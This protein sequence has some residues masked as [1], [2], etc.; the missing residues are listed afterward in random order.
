M[1]FHVHQ[2]IRLSRFSYFKIGSQGDS[3]SLDAQY[4]D[5]G[6]NK[7]YFNKAADQCYIPT[8]KILQNLLDSSAGKFRFS[9]SITG[10]LLEQAKKYRPEVIDSF[11]ALCSTGYVDVLDETYYHSLSSLYADASEFKEQVMQHNAIIRDLL[12]V[13]PQSFRNTEAI[14]S[15]KIAHAVE[16]MGYKAIITEGV[17]HILGWRSP[18]YVYKPAGCKSIRLLMRNYKLSDDVGFRFSA[19]SWKEWPLTADKYASWL[20]ATPGQVINLFMDY[21][22][23]GEHHWKD[24]GI[25]DFLNALP[26]QCLAHDNLQFSTVTQAASEFSPADQVNV[27]YEISWADAE[28]NT[29]TWL[30]N[31]IQCACFS[32]LESLLVQVRMANDSAILDTYRKLQTSDHLMYLSTKGMSDREVHNYFSPYKDSGPYDNFISFM[33]IISDFKEKVRAKIAIHEKEQQPKGAQSP[34][35]ESGEDFAKQELQ[36]P[37]QVQFA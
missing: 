23:F 11:K 7:H 27:P 19:K 25:L 16:A 24:T 21:E 9:L 1:C 20:S 28:R 30:G 2:P 36:T 3:A 35:A 37:K 14:Y 18:N 29:S 8:N 15:N 12:G 31:R 10:T 17:D 32:E 33:N 6:M 34:L 26:S 5:E 22:T 4:F 13:S